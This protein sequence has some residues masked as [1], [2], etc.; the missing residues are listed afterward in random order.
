MT[1]AFCAKCGFLACVCQILLDHEPVCKYLIAACCP[2]GI[3]CDHGRDVCPQCDPCT[4]QET[5]PA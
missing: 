4:C 5:K 3:A 1:A 2:V